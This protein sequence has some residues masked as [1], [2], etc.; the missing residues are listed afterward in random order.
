MKRSYEQKNEF[1][2]AF[3][4]QCKKKH[5]FCPG[6]P[7]LSTPVDRDI[8]TSR[9]LEDTVSVVTNCLEHMY[10]DEKFFSYLDRAFEPGWQEVL[11]L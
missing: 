6:Y 10:F 5:D 7:A 11:V 8:A 1:K 2:F 3:C 9:Q 4:E